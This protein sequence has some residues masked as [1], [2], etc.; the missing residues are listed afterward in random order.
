MNDLIRRIRE[1][2]V[3][4]EDSVCLQRAQLVTEAYRRH[5]RDPTPV[6]RAKAFA[7]VLANMDLDLDAATLRDAR[8][9]PERYGDL[10]VRVAGFSVRFIN[11]SPAEQDELIERVEVAAWTN[12][13]R[14]VLRGVVRVGSAASPH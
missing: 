2:L 3:A 6:K 10:V 7:H 11:L 8:R 12:G 14:T 13:E 1:E 9:R 4:T 5:E